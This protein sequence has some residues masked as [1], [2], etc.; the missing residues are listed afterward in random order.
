MRVAGDGATHQRATCATSPRGGRG[1]L[2]SYLNQSIRRIRP[3]RNTSREEA[4]FTRD[5]TRRASAQHTSRAT[6]GGVCLYSCINHRG[7]S[8]AQ[9]RCRASKVSWNIARPRL[10]FGIASEGFADL[11]FKCTEIFKALS[12]KEVVFALD[13]Q[14]TQHPCL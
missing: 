4:V 13:S 10:V 11:T 1:G 9:W 7:G 2:Y 8:T 14:D 3:T 6:S 5:E 12:L